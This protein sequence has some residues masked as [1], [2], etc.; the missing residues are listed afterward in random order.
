LFSS[1]YSLSGSPKMYCP[2]MRPSAAPNAKF[3]QL[4][5]PVLRKLGLYRRKCVSD[6][7]PFHIHW[8]AH[9][10]LTGGLLLPCRLS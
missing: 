6:H 1:Q 2:E 8:H 4:D 3:T 5:G 10:I 7:V 9:F